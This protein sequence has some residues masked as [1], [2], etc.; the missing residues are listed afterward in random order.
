M[1]STSNN[2]NVIPTVDPS[3]DPTSPYYVHP[4]DNPGMKLVSLKFDG[5]SYA[6]WKRSLLLSL[7]A[8]N[9][10]GFVD[11]S[12]VKPPLDDAT[13]K[14]WDRCNCMMI[15]WIL[16]VLDQD[17]ARS[18]LYY[19]TARDIW[20]NLEERF[21]QASGTTLYE[22]KQSL[23]EIKQGNDN[24]SGFYTKMKMLWDQLDSV[25]S[26]PVC[27]CTN[28]NCGL[29]TKLM[30]FKE[31]G[32]VIDFLMKMNEGYE[33]L[34]G[35]ILIMSPLPSI[36]HVY[37]L[38]VQEENHKKIYQGSQG[39]PEQRMAFATNR[40]FT[41]DRFK[42]QFSRQSQGSDPRNR[43]SSFY[44]EHCKMPGHTVQ[45]CY[46]IHG[47]PSNFRNDKRAATVQYEENSGNK[48]ELQ[49]SDKNVMF[50]ADQYQQLLKLLGKEKLTENDVH[51]DNLQGSKSAH[52][53]GKF[54]LTSVN[55]THWIV[56]SGAT[57]HM[58]SDLSFFIHVNELKGSNN[59]ITIPN[60]K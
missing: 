40:R 57:D 56:D 30:K 14:A 37:R 21:G 3:Q 16:G 47:Y 33:M 1:A 39:N 12:I 4:S 28:C 27:N 13:Y 45:R 46:K 8:K 22:I 17:I 59:L 26:V 60:G 44:C 31:D 19:T 2:N 7:T 52:V 49:S 53:A 11:G 48:A 15:S 51:G 24:I 36:S 35:S 41:Q 42:Q 20:V 29:T 38:I 43:T 5:N 55:G 34:R 10:I 32:R 58:C 50:T 18:V 6:D 9:K 25:D 54:C 23:N